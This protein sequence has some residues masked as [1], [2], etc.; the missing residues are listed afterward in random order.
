MKQSFEDFAASIGKDPAVQS[1]ESRLQHQNVALNFNFI[2]Y[3]MWFAIEKQGRI[4]KPVFL[5]LQEMIQAWHERITLALKPLVSQAHPIQQKVRETAAFALGVEQKMLTEAI[6][7]EFPLLRNE[8]QQLGDASYNLAHYYKLFELRLD[9]E[10]RN[11][12]IALL[13]LIF[14]NQPTFEVSNHLRYALSYAKI[15]QNSGA[16]MVLKELS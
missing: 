5:K 6:M 7:L 11:G 13:Q 12:L 8:A 9:E 14:P 3:C 4:R 15:N 2:I 10:T 1:I 16:Q